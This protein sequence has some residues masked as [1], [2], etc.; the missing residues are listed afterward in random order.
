[1]QVDVLP[2]L[3]AEIFRD[4]AATFSVV[5]VNMAALISVGAKEKQIAKIRIL[6]AEG[7]DS[8]H[9]MEP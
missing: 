2:A 7:V 3:F 6:C 5:K 1:V 4:F 8:R 9:N